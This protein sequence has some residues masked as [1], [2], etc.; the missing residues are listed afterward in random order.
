MILIVNKAPC[1]L[2][3]GRPCMNKHRAARQSAARGEKRS[4]HHGCSAIS[5]GRD[6]PLSIGSEEN[7]RNAGQDRIAA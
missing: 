7:A 4:N 2:E 6:S 5:R 3:K 1:R